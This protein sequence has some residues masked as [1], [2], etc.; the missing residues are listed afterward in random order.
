MFTVKYYA[1]KHLKSISENIP[2][3]SKTIG[4]C[5]IMTFVIVKEILF[6]FTIYM[7]VG[8]YGRFYC[9]CPCTMCTPGALGGHKRVLDPLELQLQMAV[10]HRVGAGN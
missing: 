2:Y 1:D 10:S 5:R 7:Y 6:I 3:L 4:L 8:R 9:L